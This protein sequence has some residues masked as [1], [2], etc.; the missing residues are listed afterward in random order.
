MESIIEESVLK[1]MIEKQLFSDFQFVF[2]SRRSCVLQLLEAMEYW[3]EALDSGIPVD[4]AILDFRK[5]FDAVPQR[6]LL[7]SHRHMDSK[8]IY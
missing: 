6:R 7:K 1:H 2:R 4:V 3:T 8:A 5:A